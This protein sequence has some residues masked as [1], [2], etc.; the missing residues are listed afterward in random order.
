MQ[1]LGN[2]PGKRQPCRCGKGLRGDLTHQ[3]LGRAQASLLVAGEHCVTGQKFTRTWPSTEAI[4]VSSADSWSTHQLRGRLAW[5]EDGGKLYFWDGQLWLRWDDPDDLPGSEEDPLRIKIVCPQNAGASTSS[6]F[7]LDRILD[8]LE[9]KSVEEYHFSEGKS[10]KSNAVGSAMQQLGFVST[11]PGVL[12][13]RW[14]TSC[15]PISSS[16]LNTLAWL[17]DRGPSSC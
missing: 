13:G 1:N 8:L 17:L 15:S 11:T 4:G 12:P 16:S 3:T 14:P 7:K 9:A 6:D 2:D 10:G 5:L